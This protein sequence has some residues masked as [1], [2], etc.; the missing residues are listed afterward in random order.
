MIEI[1]EATG[2]PDLEY[3]DIERRSTWLKARGYRVIHVTPEE[4]DQGLDG[5]IEAIYGEV[6][7]IAGRLQLD[8]PGRRV[9]DTL[10]MT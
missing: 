5:V 7:D 9:R 3:T 6:L 2:E 1:D 8:A 4:V 10:K